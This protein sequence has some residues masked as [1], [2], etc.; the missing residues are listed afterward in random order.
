MMS[1][2][3][4][5]LVGV[6]GKVMMTAV[7]AATA[8]AGCGDPSTSSPVGSV[9]S[10][11][12]PPATRT[13]AL[14]PEPG[15]A[16][17]VTVTAVDAG[18]VDEPCPVDEP[19]DMNATESSIM[20]DETSRLEPMLG[21]VLQY[22]S[23]HQDV[24]GGY[25]LHWHSSG[26]ASVFASFTGDLAEHRA[27]LTE[28]VEYPDELIVCQAPASE[29]DRNA[30]QATLIEELRGRFTEIG[31]GGKAGAVIVGLNPTEES[32]AAELVER[33]G[34]A[35]DLTVGAL[36]YPLADAV[37]DCGP[38]LEPSLIDGLEIKILNTAEPVE[39]TEAG[40]IALTI[41]L[42]NTG[43]QSIR[44]D[45]GHPSTMITDAHGEA[46]TRDTRSV[47]D[48]GIVIALEPGASQNFDVDVSLASCD[49]AVGYLLPPGDHFLVVSFYNGQTQSNM[50]SGPLPITIAGR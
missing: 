10:D 27:A 33:Y 31:S 28:L 42:T 22:G 25:G 30:I 34:P 41:Q 26:D 7:V 50:N 2:K 9:E 47:A 13:V 4:L 36:K 11:T 45:S 8:I 20:F 49:P 5:I 17:Y 14:L 19:V 12:A 3:R 23:E 29:A 24:F 16:D 18:E 38:A 43:D 37:A 48:V 35:V 32:L 44:F 15:D 39:V 40:T 1:R 46:R 6:P 21:A